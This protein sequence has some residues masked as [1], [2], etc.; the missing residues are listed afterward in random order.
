MNLMPPGAA[1][2][3]GELSMLM[4]SILDNAFMR[5]VIMEVVNQKNRRVLGDNPELRD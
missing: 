2:V 1:T 5:V 4:L 3:A